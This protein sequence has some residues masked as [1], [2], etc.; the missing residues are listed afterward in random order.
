MKRKNCLSEQDL[1]LYYYAERSESEAETSHI[2]NCPLCAERL[3]SL[4]NDLAQLPDLA[5][6]SD[7]EAGIR[8]A[9]RV[10]EKLH[11]PRRSWLPALGASTVAALALVAAF[12]LWSPQAPLQQPTRLAAPSLATLNI[13]EDMLDIDFLEDF[14]LLQEL[15]LLSQIE[16]V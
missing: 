14:E 16:G 11:E 12:T 10:N 13:N 4:R 8:M 9:A 1:T 3:S 6:E 5:N 7:P 15:E 2:A